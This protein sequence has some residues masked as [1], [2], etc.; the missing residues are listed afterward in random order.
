MIK[1]ESRILLKE[2]GTLNHGRALREL[3]DQEMEKINDITTCESWDEAIGRKYAIL[4]IKEIF[5]AIEPERETKKR[6]N[7]YT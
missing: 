2:L 3:L 7:T 4:L 6:T 1:Q 5:M